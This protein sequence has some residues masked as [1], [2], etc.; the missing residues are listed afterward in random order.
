[1]VGTMKGHARAAFASENAEMPTTGPRIVNGTA[2]TITLAA[3]E[4]RPRNFV[5]S[6][7]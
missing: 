3:T 1:M 5:V 4:R 7:F 2:M 6:Q